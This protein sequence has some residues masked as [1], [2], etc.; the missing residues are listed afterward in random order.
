MGPYPHAVFFIC[1]TR[2]EKVPVKRKARKSKKKAIKRVRKN[3]HEGSKLA[4][5]RSGLGRGG[6]YINLSE[7]EWERYKGIKRSTLKI[8]ILRR[9]GYSEA[10]I[11]RFKRKKKTK[12]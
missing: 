7:K 9:M 6:G 4:K 2:R 11:K 1:P 3:L 10:E 12:K 8:G 5:K